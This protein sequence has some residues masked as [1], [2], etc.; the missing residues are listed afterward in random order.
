MLYII[1]AA[2]NGSVLA[3][4]LHSTVVITL[5]L[6]HYHSTGTFGTPFI[7]VAPSYD[8][9]LIPQVPY[10]SSA[11]PWHDNFNGTQLLHQWHFTF[12]L[13]LSQS[14][15]LKQKHFLSPWELFGHHHHH[16]THLTSR[17]CVCVCYSV[18]SS[19][20]HT[21][22]FLW[23]FLISSPHPYLL[24]L[25]LAWLLFPPSLPSGK[26]QYIFRLIERK[27]C[28]LRPQV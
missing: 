23:S 19:R 10:I 11:L 9:S 14:L 21:T 22:S 12:F 15:A 27:V 2:F 16:H 5:L 24:P 18:Y 26:H 8:I 17:V 6:L 28:F 3:P 7:H 1:S 25:P 13:A 20:H 4:N